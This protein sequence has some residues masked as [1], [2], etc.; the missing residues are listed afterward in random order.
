M[1]N[2]AF[3][4]LIFG[5]IACG[6]KHED[7]KLS[8]KKE[9]NVESITG[10]MNCENCRMN[11]K[12]FIST[13]HAVKLKNGDSHFYCSINCSTIAGGKLK[14]NVE[15]VYAI[16]YG[17]TKYFPA[18]EMYYVIGSSL[19]G[20]MTQISKFAFIDSSKAE[21]FNTTFSGKEVVG[22]DEAFNMSVEEILNRKKK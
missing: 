3:L 1:K 11:L 21:S 5:I 17:Q 7:K 19:R 6:E 16:D 2:M 22:Y 4:I 20:T 8:V 13:S 18:N 15:T 14:D 9:I 10:E 12:K